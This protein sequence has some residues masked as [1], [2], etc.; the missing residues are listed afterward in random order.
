MRQKQ[1][2][3]AMAVAGIIVAGAGGIIGILSL[4]DAIGATHGAGSTAHYIV[5]T[6]LALGIAAAGAVLAVRGEH[7]W[8]HLGDGPSAWAANEGWRTYPRPA[9]ARRR[10]HAPGT[11]AV[12]ALIFTGVTAFLLVSTV[13]VY[14]GAERSS[15]TQAHGVTETAMVDTVQNIAN[16]SRHGNVTYTNQ[17]TLTVRHPKIGDGT[18]TVYGQ[19]MAS[20]QPGNTLTVLVDPKQPSYAEIPGAP[21]DSTSSW[22]LSLLFTIV[23]GAITVVICR[24]AVVMQL[25]H[26]RVSRG[27]LHS[28]DTY[29]DLSL[30]ARSPLDRRFLPHG[31][32]A[33]S[34][35]PFPPSS[36]DFPSKSAESRAPGGPMQKRSPLGDESAP[37]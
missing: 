5:L 20:V 15:Y 6:V 11:F 34:L 37:N 16:Q 24:H 30:P 36:R 33:S 1:R 13:Q 17:V 35:T 31:R 8:H 9:G 28:V 18:A 27:R 26:R 22:I 19:G 29:A 10:T 21:Y 7:Q 3:V 14:S 23:F 12:Q 2:Y 25:R 4:L 32:K